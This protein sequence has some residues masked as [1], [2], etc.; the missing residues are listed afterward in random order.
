MRNKISK[1]NNYLEIESQNE[2][3]RARKKDYRVRIDFSQLSSYNSCLFIGQDIV[4][5]FD[6]CQVEEMLLPSVF[7]VAISPRKINTSKIHLLLA[8]QI[9]H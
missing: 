2:R 1:P 8:F 4:F 6:K 3:V 7:A 9:L 5:T